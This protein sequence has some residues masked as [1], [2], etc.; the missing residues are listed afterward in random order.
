MENET[1]R[2][3]YNI[4][5]VE[6]DINTNN[7]YAERIGR[8]FEFNVINTYDGLEGLRKL[9]YLSNENI[10]VDLI[11]TGIEMPNMG[12]FELIESIQKNPKFSSIPTM[13]SSHLG[14]PADF[15]RAKRLGVH[16][17]IVRG[18]TTPNQVVRI[19]KEVLLESHNSSYNLKINP[20]SEDYRK[21]VKDFFGLECSNCDRDDQMPV[22]ISLVKSGKTNL[23][24]IE[25]DCNRCKKKI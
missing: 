25:Q 9:N 22:K 17:F 24:S 13:I 14:R 3:T 19:I 7:M 1:K 16:H 23:F 15:D 18:E 5:L 12:G 4:L 2:K 21:F 6:D 8:E 11:F 10:S 20:N